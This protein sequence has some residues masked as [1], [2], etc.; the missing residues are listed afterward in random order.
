[1]SSAVEKLTPQVTESA[2]DPMGAI[3]R[4]IVNTRYEDLDSAV[5]EKA[6]IRLMDAVAS[7]IAGTSFEGSQ[8]VV[9]FVTEQGGKDESTIPVFGNKVPA[10]AAGFAMGY[11]ARARDIGTVAEHH[12]VGH[13]GEFIFPAMLPVAESKRTSGREFLLAWILG[14]EILTRLGKAECHKIYFTSYGHYSWYVIWGVT[15]AVARLLGLDVEKTWN[16][17]GI[18][19]QQVSGEEQ[20]FLDGAL[21]VKLIHSWRAQSAINCALLAQKG[22]TGPR[23]VLCGKNGYFTRFVPP[24]CEA[25]LTWITSNLGKEWIG[26]DS[27]IKPYPSCKCTHAAAAGVVKLM[28]EHNIKLENIREIDLGLHPTCY[29][30]VCTPP[31]RKYDPQTVTDAQFSAPYVT[32]VAA[33]KGSVSFEDFSTEARQRSDVRALMRR[34]KLH[35]DPGLGFKE[36]VVR[37]MTGRGEVFQERVNFVKGHPFNPMSWEEEIAKFRGC[38][39]VAA[40]PFGSSRVEEMIDALREIEKIDD[41]RKVAQLLVP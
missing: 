16:A 23:R 8:E 11:M 21:S 34:I 14:K 33:I 13:V 6:K 37:I 30:I 10:S 28:K 41:M 38:V 5:I 24:Q 31:A 20:S 15:A 40:K 19:Y 18:A 36:T 27:S 1:M 4:F 7:V 22:F 26:L 9:D 17:M 12:A 25:D 35:E 29:T 2:E 3:A 39:A 32:A